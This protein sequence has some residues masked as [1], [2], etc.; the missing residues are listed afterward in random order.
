MKTNIYFWSYPTEWFL[1]WEMLQT[2]VVEKINTHFMFYN[3]FKKLFHLWDNVEKY[4][5]AG[6]AAVD[7]MVH[8]HC[9]LDT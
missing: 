2:K 9:M 6:Q 8:V 5:R 4:H 3:F 1:K 7:N